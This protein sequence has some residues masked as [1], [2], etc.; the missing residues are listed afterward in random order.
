M[1]AQQARLGNITRASLDK[2]VSQ[3][4]KNVKDFKTQNKI[5][6]SIPEDTGTENGLYLEQRSGI[7]QA[8]E[9]H[10]TIKKGERPTR[11][12]TVPKSVEGKKRVSYTVRT[13]LEVGITPEE[14]IPI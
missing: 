7:E 14:M 9:K 10:G 12:I 11:D 3:F 8:A 2:S 6:Y 5:K 13:A 4:Q 1:I